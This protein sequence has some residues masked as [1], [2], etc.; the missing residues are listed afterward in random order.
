[1]HILFLS[2]NFPPECNAP[3][4][5]LHEHARRWVAAG[6]RVTVVTCAPN[7]PRGRVFDGY[8]NELLH[9]ETV[10]GIEVLR[11][12]TYIAPNQ[13]KVRRTLDYL[14][15]LVAGFWGALLPRNVDLVVATSPQF[16]SAVAGWLVSVV[17]RKPFVF[18]L[19][20]LW[21][22]SISAVGAARSGSL[23][24]RLLER[25][26]LFLYRRARRVLAVTHAFREDLAR[27]GVDESK[28]RVVTNGVDLDLYQPR[29]KDAELVAELGLRG[30]FVVGYLGTH[31]LSHGLH[32]ALDA[33]EAIAATR[34]DVHFLFVGDG[35]AREGLLEDARAR[36]LTNVTFRPAVPKSEM[37]RWWS[38][39]D[40]ALVS[41]KDTAVFRTVIPSKI[42]E[43][44]GMGLPIVLAGPD[45]E[46]ASIVR[47]TRAGVVTP[48]EDPDALVE[49]LTSLREDRALR[50]RYSVAS[51]SS[52]SRFGRDELAAAMLRELQ[53]A[54]RG[55]VPPRIREVRPRPRVSPADPVGADAPGSAQR[56][57]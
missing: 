15:F 3:A 22:A 4:T 2:D 56:T 21:P 16:F 47:G 46:A 49:V 54:V 27:R 10:D 8:R 17:R 28:V 31:G 41:L 9:R 51:Q 57:R 52:A 29:E 38:L 30:R 40:V 37:P 34:P 25:V 48:P 35:A 20:D 13:G 14:S 32:S 42:F 11:V 12:K 5:R 55:P 18:E 23:S 19:R 33:A 43:A 7:F 39:C 26:E 45:G 53:E 50:T 44:M 6:H 24:V 1:M 36:G